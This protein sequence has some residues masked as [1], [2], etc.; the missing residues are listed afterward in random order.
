MGASQPEELVERAAAKLYSALALTDEASVAGVVRAHLHARENGLHFICG[1]ELLLTTER[2]HVH[3]RVVL[4]APNK[5]G[6]GNL[7][8]CIAL[9]RRR[10]SVQK[11]S[12]LQ[13]D[14]ADVAPF[15]VA[16]FPRASRVEG[17][18]DSPV[19][20]VSLWEYDEDQPGHRYIVPELH[21][22]SKPAD[23]GVGIWSRP[24]HEAPRWK[25]G[26]RVDLPSV[27]VRQVHGVSIAT[28]Q[29]WPLL[30]RKSL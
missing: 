24:S 30:I 17:A 4:L 27:H 29:A 19:G 20:I 28:G 12:A 22:P 18:Q 26:L 23:D 11:P 10:A 21:V 5:Q 3:A 15:N 7:C 14:D 2:G 9:A 16:L 13:A 1:S 8:E 6:W 25:L